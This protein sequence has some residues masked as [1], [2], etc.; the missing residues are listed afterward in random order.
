MQTDET[1]TG[2][3]P[4]KLAFY[5]TGSYA[6]ILRRCVDFLDWESTAICPNFQAYT[7]A[8]KEPRLG[9]VDYLYGGFN[10]AFERVDIDRFCKEYAS[11][12]LSEV[13]LVDKTHFK[14]KSGDYQ[15]RYVCAMGEKIAEVFRRT[16]PDCVFFPI[17]ETIDAMLT[18][19]LAQHFGIQPIVSSH[20]RFTGRYFFSDSHLELLPKYTRHVARPETD[21]VWAERFI[22]TYR[23]KPSPFNIKANI[24]AVDV[25]EDFGHDL[26]AMGRMRQNIRLKSGV[27]KHNQLINLWINF[28][29]RFEA[30]FVPVRNAAFYF[31]ERFYIKP[32][33][34]PAEGYD[35]FPLHFSPESSINV[36]A[37]FFIDQTRIVDKILLERSGNRALVLKEHPAMYGFRPRGFFRSLKSRPF[38]LFV[39][40]LTPS[41]QLIRGAA[42]VYSVTGTACLEAFFLGVSWVQFGNNFLSDWVKQ[43]RERSEAE[44][45]LEFIRDVL[46]VSKE[47]VLYSPGRSFADDQILFSKANVERICDHLKFHVEQNSHSAAS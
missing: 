27:E 42:T 14:K 20:A 31:T 2:K 39:S 10:E 36:P 47:F 41:T 1:K 33:P 15:L 45:P 32:K 38:V 30:I 13:L 40:R 46:S 3:T 16:R 43:R 35:F 21:V 25:Y 6:K 34:A 24:A 11:I 7:E 19:R 44:T 28:Q 29:V 18:Y 5:M 12:N 9:A 23:A 8:K 17:I 37:P 26:G 22:E 4:V